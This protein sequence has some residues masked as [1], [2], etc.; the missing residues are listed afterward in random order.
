MD[1]QDYRLSGS[2]VC[3]YTVQE[4]ERFVLYQEG[5]LWGLA[6]LSG[7]GF[8]FGPLLGEGLADGLQ[9]KRSAGVLRDWVAGRIELPGQ[10]TG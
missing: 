1:F 4:Q 10:N 3:F 7:H 6:G 2:K 5:C 8:K 9:G